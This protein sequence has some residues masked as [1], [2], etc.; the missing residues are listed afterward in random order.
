MKQGTTLRKDDPQ[1]IVQEIQIWQFYQRVY[2]WTR[3]NQLE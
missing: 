3:I 2:S 1:G